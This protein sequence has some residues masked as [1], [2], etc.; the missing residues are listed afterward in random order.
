MAG[1]KKDKAPKGPTATPIPARLRDR[2]KAE[3]VPALV[4]EFDETLSTMGDPRMNGT[5]DVYESYPRFSRMRPQL[6]GFA[7]Q[8]KYNP[9]YAE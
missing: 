9:K 8:G 7:E 5:G 4:K 2:Y 3:I 6:G 1:K